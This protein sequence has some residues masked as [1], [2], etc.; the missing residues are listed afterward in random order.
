MKTGEGEWCPSHLREGGEGEAAEQ[1]RLLDAF[2]LEEKGE[3][4]DVGARVAGRI[5]GCAGCPR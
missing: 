3:K 4:M 1:R 5:L 2:S